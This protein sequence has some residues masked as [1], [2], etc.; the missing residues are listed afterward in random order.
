MALLYPI[1]SDIVVVNGLD[2]N[3]ENMSL[4]P[5]GEPLIIPFILVSLIIAY[6]LKHVRDKN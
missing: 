3:P 1:D 2:L 6:I 4:K 5:L